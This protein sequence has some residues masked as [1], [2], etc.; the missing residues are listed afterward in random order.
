[1]EIEVSIKHVEFGDTVYES[2]AVVDTT[3]AV[4]DVET[5]LPVLE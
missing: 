4:N 1:M 5:I 3:L 2:N